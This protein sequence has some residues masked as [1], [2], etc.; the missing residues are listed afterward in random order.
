VVERFDGGDFPGTITT[1]STFAVVQSITVPAGS[2]VVTGSVVMTDFA[3]T[4]ASRHEVIAD[5]TNAGTAV[6]ASKVYGDLSEGLGQEGTSPVPTVT[7]T[8]RAVI[9]TTGASTTIGLRA[10][11]ATGT[12]VSAFNRRLEALQVASVT[13]Q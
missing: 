13:T 12:N 5:L 10:C 6:P 8:P 11:K 4:S 9:T 2:W 7:L 3:T 1:C